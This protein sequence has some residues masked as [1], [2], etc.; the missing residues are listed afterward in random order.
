MLEYSPENHDSLVSIIRSKDWY[1]DVMSETIVSDLLIGLNNA[2]ILGGVMS[3]PADLIEGTLVPVLALSRI[4]TV[5]LDSP[6]ESVVGILKQSHEPGTKI[7]PYAFGPKI[8]YT[9]ENEL[10]F[11]FRY[12]IVE[13]SPQS[14][15]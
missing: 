14:K 3:V 1:V 7:Y 2:G 15:A 4:F 9:P 10:Q 13:P 5:S 8:A 12:G 6:V 11:V